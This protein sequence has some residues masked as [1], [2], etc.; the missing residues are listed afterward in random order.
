M[1]MESKSKVFT[2]QDL[3]KL[4]FEQDESIKFVQKKKTPQT[5]HL[6]DHFHQVFV[7]DA[8]QQ[9]VSCNNC[10]VLLA[11]QSTNGTNNLKSHLNFC[12]AVQQKKR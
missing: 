9:F 7:D 1:A 6:W 5:S 3:E 10:K 4:I 11:H 8:Q 12:T 2:R